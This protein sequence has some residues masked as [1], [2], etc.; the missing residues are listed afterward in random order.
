M[1]VSLLIIAALTLGLTACHQEGPAE[2]AGKH[3]DNAGESVSDTL[4]PPQGPS[5]SVGR[6]VDRALGD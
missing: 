6:K 1:R 3:L 4:N 5:Q 2:R